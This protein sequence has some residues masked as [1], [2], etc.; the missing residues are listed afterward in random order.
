M[1]YAVDIFLNPIQ[2]LQIAQ[3]AFALFDIRLHHV[4]LAALLEVARLTFRKLGFGKLACGIFKELFT[5]LGLKLL[6][7]LLIAK[8]R[9]ASQPKMCEWCNLRAQGAGN[10]GSSGWHGRL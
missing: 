10:H 1:K 7:H 3:P 5:Q 8:Q 2:G 4:A 9:T 6:E